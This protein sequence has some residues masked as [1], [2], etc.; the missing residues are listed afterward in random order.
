MSA[1]TYN[2]VRNRKGLEV[3]ENVISVKGKG[4]MTTSGGVFLLLPF[5]LETFF[6]PFLFCVHSLDIVNSRLR[7]L[8]GMEPRY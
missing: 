5:K 8:T 7:D 6:S 3:R 4:E 2:L 1:D